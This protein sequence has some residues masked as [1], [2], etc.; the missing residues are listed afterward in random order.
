[1]LNM[2]NEEIIFLKCVYW[3]V[4]PLDNSIMIPKIYFLLSVR[5]LEMPVKRHIQ[6]EGKPQS[7]SNSVQSLT[8]MDQS[9]ARPINT[10]SLS[11]LP[12]KCAKNLHVSEMLTI[13]TSRAL[14]FNIRIQLFDIISL[15]RCIFLLENKEIYISKYI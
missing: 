10:V 7:L 11:I 1:M 9:A 3:Y 13:P 5:F 6:D 12:E 14:E 2:I 8:S 15:M 4:W